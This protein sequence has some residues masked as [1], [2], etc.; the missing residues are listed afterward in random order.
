MSSSAPI[1]P[2]HPPTA[3]GIAAVAAVLRAG[4][5]AIIPTDTVYGLAARAD[6][7]GAMTRLYAAKARDPAKPVALLVD[8]VEAVR[9]A[10]ARLSPAALAL[11]DAFW[12]GALTLV[13]PAATPGL[14]E[15]FRVPDHEAARALI[16]A[17]AA[18]LAVSSANI[19]NHPPA[20][21]AATA[22]QA[23]APHPEAVLDA[24]PVP[25]ARPSTVVRVET[26]R[27]VVLRQGPISPARLAATARL[28]AV[29]DGAVRSC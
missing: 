1:A 13:L 17:V 19:S 8:G 11:A 23:L 7:P 2:F 15:G 16:R 10:G 9:A 14:W 18:P 26:D 4:R 29:L 25:G 3:E 6:S 12:P 22:W 27:L 24:G 5:L 28:P 21:D 20:C